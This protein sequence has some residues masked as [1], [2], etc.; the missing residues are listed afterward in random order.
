MNEE[1]YVN[2]EKVREITGNPDT[3]KVSKFLKRWVDRG[4]LIKIETGSKKKVKYRLPIDREQGF[5]F[6]FHRYEEIIRSFLEALMAH[7]LELLKELE[8]EVGKKLPRRPFDKIMDLGKRGF[9]ADER[10]RVIGINLDKMELKAT[11]Y[12]LPRRRSLSRAKRPCGPI[13]GDWQKKRNC[14]CGKPKSS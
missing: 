10:G 1:K 13:T 12:P 3:S 8:Q 11:P 5:L 6:A 9:S 2:N 14:P 7:D 4:L